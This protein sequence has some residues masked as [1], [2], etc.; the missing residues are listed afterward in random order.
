MNRELLHIIHEAELLIVQQTK[1][2]ELLESQLRNAYYELKEIQQKLPED[3]FYRVHQS[4]LINLM[5][6]IEYDVKKN[7][8][9]LSNETTIPVSR[10]KRALLKIRLSQKLIS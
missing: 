9:V 6:V 10:S 3:H 8:I 4:Y 7:E 1:L 5:H 2:S